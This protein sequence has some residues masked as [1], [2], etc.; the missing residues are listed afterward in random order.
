MS[1]VALQRAENL[2]CVLHPAMQPARVN[3]AMDMVR[4]DARGQQ[5]VFPSILLP[6]RLGDHGGDTCLAEPLRTGAMPGK[7][8]VKLPPGNSAL[9][10]RTQRLF[11]ALRKCRPEPAGKRAGVPGAPG[12][13]GPGVSPP[14]VMWQNRLP[15]RDGTKPAENR[16]MRCAMRLSREN[17]WF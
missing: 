4:H 3:N 16:V 14:V 8:P 9:P 10:R 1:R 12:R 13:C 15:A 7:V 17:S 2:W 5:I 11:S 6:E